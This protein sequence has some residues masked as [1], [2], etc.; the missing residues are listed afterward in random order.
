MNDETPRM[1]NQE[2]DKGK[3]HWSYAYQSA[4]RGWINPCL[5]QVPSLFQFCKPMNSLYYLSSFAM[6]ITVLKMCITAGTV[7]ALAHSGHSGDHL[8]HRSSYTEPE[9]RP[10]GFQS[11]LH[12]L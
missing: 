2:R 3:M 8:I 5:K 7:P 6:L 1:W 11:Q 9:N 4:C 12:L 10:T